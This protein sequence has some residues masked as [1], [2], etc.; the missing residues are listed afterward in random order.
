ESGLVRPA[1]RA[2]PRGS[3]S[4]R[5]VVL[6]SPGV[7]GRRRPCHHVPAPTGSHGPAPGP[8]Q[9]QPPPPWT[10]ERAGASEARRPP[11]HRQPVA[12]PRPRCSAATDRDRGT[13]AACQG[14][15]WQISQGARAEKLGPSRAKEQ[16]AVNTRWLRPPV[17]LC[18]DARVRKEG[19]REPLLDTLRG[20][21]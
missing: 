8:E 16:A 6:L 17:G 10:A 19:V 14:R 1:L 11:G 15:T 2:L 3:S 4:E 13:D 20:L 5:P 9:R 12:G 18:G 21:P 7:L